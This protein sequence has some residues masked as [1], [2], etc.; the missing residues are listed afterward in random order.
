MSDNQ[1]DPEISYIEVSMTL[2]QEADCCSSDRQFLTIKTQNG[3]CDVKDCF[4]VIETERWAVE[5]AAQL[6]EHI[7]FATD[8]IDDFLGR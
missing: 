7:R 3:A 4:Y 5:D 1:N 2:T 8:K 6:I